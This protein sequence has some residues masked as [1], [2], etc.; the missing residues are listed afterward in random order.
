MAAVL[1]GTRGRVR[2]CALDSE[3]HRGCHGGFISS[4]KLE[5]ASQIVILRKR[6]RLSCFCFSCTKLNSCLALLLSEETFTFRKKKCILHNVPYHLLSSYCVPGAQHTLLCTRSSGHL[7]F[8]S[9]QP[10]GRGSVGLPPC[11]DEAAEAQ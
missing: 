10:P 1:P 4:Q 7:I 3:L 8:D 9:Q 2:P 5:L 11:R 6:F